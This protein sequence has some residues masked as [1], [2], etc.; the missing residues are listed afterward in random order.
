MKVTVPLQQEG[1]VA[2]PHAVRHELGLEH[3]DLVELD[4]RIALEQGQL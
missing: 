3:G 1:R 2:I 4:V